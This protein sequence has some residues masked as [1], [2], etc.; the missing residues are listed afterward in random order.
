MMCFKPS[1]SSFFLY[2]YSIFRQLEPLPSGSCL[3]FSW[4]MSVLMAFLASW[5]T[6]ARIILLH[7]L[8]IP[9]ISHFSKKFWLHLMG[10]GIY[11][12]I[13]HSLDAEAPVFS[14]CTFYC[15]PGF[16]TIVRI[17]RANIYDAF[18]CVRKY[19]KYCT[20]SISFYHIT[21]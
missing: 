16:R 14:S 4:A 11:R 10:D 18:I 12:F 6:C 21:L 20:F 5:I 7:F 13:V 2:S 8:S 15:L 3:H 9:G 17:R 1:T 19:F